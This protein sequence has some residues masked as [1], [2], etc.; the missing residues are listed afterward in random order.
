MNPTSVIRFYTGTS[1]NQISQIIDDYMRRNQDWEITSVSHFLFPNNFMSVA[2]SLKFKGNLN[3]KSNFLEAN[4]DDS[5][6]PFHLE[7]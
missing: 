4:E 7:K 3:S 1:Y 5:N 2:I 6:K